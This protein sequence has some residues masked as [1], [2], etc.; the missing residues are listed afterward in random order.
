M[1]ARLT[2]SSAGQFRE[3]LRARARFYVKSADDDKCHTY[4]H[5]TAM[6]R[7]DY[8]NESFP[9]SL[10]CCVVCG[11]SRTTLDDVKLSRNVNPSL[12]RFNLI[13]TY[14]NMS[15]KW[16]ELRSA[17]LLNIKDNLACFC[18]RRVSIRAIFR[19][20]SAVDFALRACRSRHVRCYHRVA[21]AVG[22]DPRLCRAPCF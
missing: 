3:C 8:W 1:S 7:N 13:T 12:Q 14:G 10:F 5:E 16:S 4:T 17:P 6:R 20:V 9:S 11:E 2:F 18:Q 21:I 19:T 22:S 15:E